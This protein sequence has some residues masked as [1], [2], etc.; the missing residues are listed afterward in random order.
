MNDTRPKSAEKSRTLGHAG[1]AGRVAD[2]HQGPKSFAVASEKRAL[3]QQ[4]MEQVC[5]RQNLNQAYRRVKANKGAAGID[6]MTVEEL[7]PWLKIHK[8]GLIQSLLDGSYAPQVVRRVDIPKPGGGSRQLGI[9]TVVDRVVQQAILQVLTPIIDPM[10][11]LS[12]YGFRPGRS[13][14]QALTAARNFV[15]D[16]QEVVVDI[17]LEAFFDRVNHDILMSRVSRHVADK[18]LLRIVRRFLEAGIMQGGVVVSREEGTPQ[19]GPLSPLLSNVLLDDLDKE[20]ERRGH[21]FCRYADDC[22]IYVATSRAGERV[23]S[24]AT[25]FLEKVLRLKVNR[26]KSAVAHVKER[27]FLG[28]RLIGGG[29]LGIAPQSIMRLR[30]KIRACTGRR[31]RGQSLSV[32][33]AKLNEIISGWVQ[34]FRMAEARTRLRDLDSWI[35][36][37]LRVIRLRQCKRRRSVGRF[38]IGIGLPAWQAWRLAGSSRGW[39]CLAGSPQS[40]QAMSNKWF[41]QQG[42]VSLVRRFDAAQ[43]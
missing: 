24:S 37:R 16:G 2:M 34:Y 15:A 31:A 14:H 41:E 21:R 38:L 32:T 6:G 30:D 5:D 25:E 13:A 29:R 43:I 35:R 17:D 12:S 42:F 20:L 26:E 9:P 4:V 36:H 22:N 33:I 7:L 8:E 39:W 1:G 27:K 10:F 18:R 28:Y 3:T 19:G 23:M 40:C 11:S